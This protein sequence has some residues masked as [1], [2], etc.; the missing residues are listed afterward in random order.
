MV[1][2]T[3]G[4]GNRWDR[5]QERNDEVVVRDTHGV[6]W[7]RRGLRNFRVEVERNPSC[8]WLVRTAEGRI[9]LKEWGIREQLLERMGIDEADGGESTALH[10][11]MPGKVLEVCVADGQP[12]E[13]GDPLVILEAMKMEN[14]LRATSDGAVRRVVV[15]AGEAVE[16]DALLLEFD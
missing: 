14:V 15:S 3:D 11:P 7:V 9:R 4:N 10:A 5:N 2:Y 6:W 1:A 8:G 13:Q 16:K 12:F